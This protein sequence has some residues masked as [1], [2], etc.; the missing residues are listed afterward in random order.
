MV[1]RSNECPFDTVA[2]CHGEVD[3]KFIVLRSTCLTIQNLVKNKSDKRWFAE[4]GVTPKTLSG[5]KE[6][7]H[8]INRFLYREVMTPREKVAEAIEAFKKETAWSDHF[9]IGMHIRTGSVNKERVRW[10]RFLAEDDVKLFKEYMRMLTRAYESG[11][12]LVH[13]AKKSESFVLQALK[14][15]EAKKLSVKWYVLSDQDGI[16]EAMEKE[17]PEYV[18]ETRCAMSHTNQALKSKDDPGFMCALVESSVC[19]H[20]I[21]VITPFLLFTLLCASTREWKLHGASS[22]ARK[23]GFVPLPEWLYDERKHDCRIEG[24][25]MADFPKKTK[26]ARQLPKYPRLSGSKKKRFSG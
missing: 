18:I 9:V 3:A 16:K 7:V 6:V 8:H 4:Q 14:E 26:G 23:H 2:A 13:T 19:T 17:N 5:P 21:L 20:D 1:K 12:E 11:G 15:K 25:L 24:M 22:F 10:G